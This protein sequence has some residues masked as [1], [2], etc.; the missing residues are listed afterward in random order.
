MCAEVEGGGGRDDDVGSANFE[1]VIGF[2]C[3]IVTIFS[4]PMEI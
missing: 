4:K 2:P 3:S 1:V